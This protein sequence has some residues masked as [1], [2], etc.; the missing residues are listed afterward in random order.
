ME[1]LDLDSSFMR[2]HDESQHNRHPVH[3]QSKGMD[4]TQSLVKASRVG[5]HPTCNVV[6][7]PNKREFSEAQ[8]DLW[9]RKEDFLH[10]QRE[11]CSDLRMQC[12]SRSMSV[13]EAK[14]FLYQP[15][16]D[17]IYN[18]SSLPLTSSLNRSESG[19][20]NWLHP[21]SRK[22]YSSTNL[23]S[24]SYDLDTEEEEAIYTHPSP[25]TKRTAPP[26]MINISYENL[27]DLDS[28]SDEVIDLHWN[29][30]LCVKVSQPIPLRPPSESSNKRHR[31][32]DS[33]LLSS[34]TKGMMAICGIFSFALPVVG[35]FLMNHHFSF[36]SFG[37]GY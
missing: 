28:S 21:G 31:G 20:D 11:A 8:C 5:F 6:L 22:C 23:S 19:D 24:S 25:V 9:W 17:E 15:Q 13:K 4:L 3:H 35:Y 34:E 14:T 2:V 1:H 18:D 16:K 36:F 10:F 30:N 26:A 27:V 29:L 12:V 32:E 33:S 7:I 37:G